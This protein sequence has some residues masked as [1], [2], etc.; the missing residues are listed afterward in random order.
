MADEKMTKI[1]LID[2]KERDVQH[3]A[4]ALQPI[5]AERHAE[6]LPFQDGAKALDF[7]LGDSS[8]ILVI[9]E[10]KLEGLGG[11][12][13]I[14]KI[15]EE[16]PHIPTLLISRPTDAKIA[17]KAVQTGAYDFLPKPVDPQEL[18]AVIQ[19][20]LNG[21]QIPP[22][23]GG[24]ITEKEREPARL[25][26]N[27]RAML[28]V[29]RDLAKVAATPVPVLIR[30]ETGTGKELIARAL[31]EHGHRSHKPFIAVN[32]AAIPDNLLESEL[33]G[34]EKGSFTGATHTKMGRFE[35]AIGATLF[36]DEIGDMQPLLQAKMLRVL[37]ERTVQRVGG[38]EEIPVD[39][40]VIAATHRN[41]ELMVDE[42][43]FRADLL[44][45]L[46]GSI[47]KVPPLRDRLG[48]VHLLTTHFLQVFSQELDISRHRITQEAVSFLARQTWHGNIRQLQNVLRQ[49][50]LKKRELTIDTADLSPLILNQNQGNAECT[51]SQL[52]S[53]TLAKAQNEKL[54]NGAYRE[55]IQEVEKV[56][57][58]AALTLT[59]GNITKAAKLLGLTRFT[60]REKIKTT[61]ED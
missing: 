55:I 19:E 33:F 20:A 60:L 16:K 23:E 10:Y 49:A 7:I 37:Q 42:G 6:L 52:S 54:P 26:G 29:Y 56:I 36:L 3:T 44:Y 4:K 35:Q 32:C 18:Q 38:K 43:L 31:H 11:L 17:I 39:V 1:V 48:D 51:L 47:L 40:R 14:E 45:R 58:P 13:L 12:P 25:I 30:G 34:H 28:K 21:A 50:L 2:S 59:E 57:I 27:S 5:L 61:L 15:A 24:T 53:S 41:L 46:N 9:T 22:I 8:V